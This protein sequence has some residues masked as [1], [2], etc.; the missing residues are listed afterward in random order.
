M[1]EHY[2]RKLDDK[3][4]HAEYKM[5]RAIPAEEIGW[6]NP[7]HH[8]IYDEWYDFLQK[9]IAEEFDEIIPRITYIMYLEEYPIGIIS[10]GLKMTKDGNISYCIRPICRGKDLGEKMLGLAIQEAKKLG[11]ATLCGNA[12]K[13][14]I[15]S[16]KTMEKCGFEF[17]GET[18]WGSRQ[19]KKIVN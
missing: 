3:M 6:E 11:V 14:N 19:Y 15:T 12:D 9:K 13:H 18:D 10:L 8:M 1:A 7:A 2:L 5:Y 4:S 16:W 17:V